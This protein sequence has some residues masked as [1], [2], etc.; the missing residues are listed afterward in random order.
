MILPAFID[1]IRFYIN[2]NNYTLTLNNEVY[3]SLFS[4]TIN[5]YEAKKISLAKSGVSSNKLGVY[6][7]FIN[8]LTILN[9]SIEILVVSISIASFAFNSGETFLLACGAR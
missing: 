7:I 4:L 6:D 2:Y 3:N 8:L 1:R 5:S 9:A